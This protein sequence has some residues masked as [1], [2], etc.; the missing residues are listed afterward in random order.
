M[1]TEKPV[2]PRADL[3]PDAGVLKMRALAC[4]QGQRF[5]EARTILTDLCRARK[6]DAETWFLLGALGGYLGQMDEAVRCCMQAISLRPDYV[7]AHYNLGIACRRLNR[8]REAEAGFREC[9]RLKPDYAEAWDNLGYLLQEQGRVNEA[10]A[11]YREAL[12]LRPDF[13]GTR[14]LLA[15]LGAE[16]MPD[17]AP[18]EYVRGLFDNYAGSFERDLVQNLEYRIP[19]LLRAAVGRAM[20]SRREQHLYILDLGCGTGLCG[21]LFRDLAA[22]LIGVDL[23]PGMIEKARVKSVYDELFLDDI[24]TWAPPSGMAFDLIITADVFIY[25]GELSQVFELCASLL[26][27]GGFFAF[28]TETADEETTY[29]LRATHR[30]AHSPAYIRSLAEKSGLAEVSAEEVTVRKHKDV[31]VR[32]HLFVLRKLW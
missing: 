20:G 30:Y 23:S 4:I 18:P 19:E 2:P 31:P 10:I 3:M 28:S 7:E 16:P 21:P 11:C 5:N 6:Q 22:R 15:T 26:K 9:V 13:A 17:K 14:Y 12:R 25:I 27:S 8:F 29:V 32:G 24:T 1:K